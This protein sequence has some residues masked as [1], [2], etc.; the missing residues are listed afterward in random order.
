M[1][2]RHD[3]YA[4]SPLREPFFLV[5]NIPPMPKEGDKRIGKV[6][7]KQTCLMGNLEEMTRLLAVPEITKD[8]AHFSPSKSIFANCSSRMSS[9][10]PIRLVTAPL[11][12]KPG[13]RITPDH[14]TD[15]FIYS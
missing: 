5:A 9:S 7:I 2:I 6:I 1:E 4:R 8:L 13:H 15:L 14:L 12:K 10:K 3:N 11:T